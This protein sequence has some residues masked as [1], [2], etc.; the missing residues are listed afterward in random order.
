MV[1]HNFPH[2]YALATKLSAKSKTTWILLRIYK[3][4]EI[5]AFFWTL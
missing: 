2:A 1:V 3:Q 4:R 5:W